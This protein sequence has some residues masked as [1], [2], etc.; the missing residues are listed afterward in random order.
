M[1]AATDGWLSNLTVSSMGFSSSTAAPRRRGVW[2]SAGSLKDDQPSGCGSRRRS[3]PLT[4]TRRARRRRP[5]PRTDASPRFYHPSSKNG[6]G[7]WPAAPGSGRPPGGCCWLGFE[8]CCWRSPGQLPLSLPARRWRLLPPRASMRN[9]RHPHR[10]ARLG[11]TSRTGGLVAQ[12]PAQRVPRRVPG[13]RHCL[14]QPWESAS[15]TWF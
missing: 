6:L 11:A 5:Q 7:P 2:R 3:R 1:Y 14:R 12:P 8:A 9:R 4:S 15:A 10:R 13:I